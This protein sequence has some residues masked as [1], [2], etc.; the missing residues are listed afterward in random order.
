MTSSGKDMYKGTK[1]PGQI[2]ANLTPHFKRNYANQP[3]MLEVSLTSHMHLSYTS[4]PD[5]FLLLCHTMLL[6]NSDLTSISFDV[7]NSKYLE[8]EKS[9]IL[10]SGQAQEV[11]VK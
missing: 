6:Y 7:S 1:S 4:Q 3:K 9:K 11:N 5:I 2:I 10:K 8:G